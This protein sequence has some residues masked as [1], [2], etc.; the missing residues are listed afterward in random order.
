VHTRK[1]R[2]VLFFRGRGKKL[3][4]EALS[5]LLYTL[6]LSL[7]RARASGR[8]LC[9]RRYSQE[10]NFKGAR[11][12]AII[13]RVSVSSLSKG[14]SVH[15]RDPL[16]KSVA[17]GAHLNHVRGA[18]KIIRTPETPTNRDPFDE[19][20]IRASRVAT[21]PPVVIVSTTVLYDFYDRRHIIAHVASR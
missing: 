8:K 10:R 7:S 3:F 4:Y 9:S 1:I 19:G 11:G 21:R 18:L 2:Q 15:R 5:A 20:S 12:F 16:C 14:R 17:S 6:S 13:E